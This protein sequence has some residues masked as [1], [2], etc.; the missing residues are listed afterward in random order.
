MNTKE[1]MTALLGGKTITHKNWNGKN[2]IFMVKDIIQACKYH[3]MN[4]HNEI[5]IY[6]SLFVFANN[7]DDGWEIYNPPV[8]WVKE[9][10]AYYGAEYVKYAD[11]DIAIEYIVKYADDDVALLYN[12]ETKKSFTF[13]KKMWEEYH[14]NFVKV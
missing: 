6:N 5:D 11:D 7:S 14:K 13:T 9:G 3:I 8:D 4:A 10:E 1:A 12:S 2:H